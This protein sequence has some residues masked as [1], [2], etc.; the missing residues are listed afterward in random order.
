MKVQALH[1]GAGEDEWL[2]TESE[3][4]WPECL[5]AGMDVARPGVRFCAAG[6]DGKALAHSAQDGS[7]MVR[8][9]PWPRARARWVTPHSPRSLR[10]QDARITARGASTAYSGTFRWDREHWC[11]DFPQFPPGLARPPAWRL[12]TGWAAYLALRLSSREPHPARRCLV[13]PAVVDALSF[14][15]S[16][17]R[18]LALVVPSAACPD[19]AALA[20]TSRGD[21][22]RPAIRVVV[23]GGWRRGCR[24]AP[25]PTREEALMP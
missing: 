11:T 6:P 19:S 16:V 3:A 10:P 13:H 2:F 17:L 8:V 20:L 1:A 25:S 5:V 14:P 22:R 9:P 12:C 21:G 15:L 4:A 18:A 7:A 23:L 24:G